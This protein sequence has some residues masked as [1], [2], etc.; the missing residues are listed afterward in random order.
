[1][2]YTA[3][4]IQIALSTNGFPVAV[5]GVMGP[6]TEGAISSFKA[7][8]GLRRRPLI[9]PLTAALLFGDREPQAITGDPLFPPWVNELGRHMHWHEITNNTELPSAAVHRLRNPGSSPARVPGADHRRQYRN[10][11]Q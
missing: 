6:E 4:Q 9:G 11:R 3:R 1:M 5:D 2:P 7:S 10:Q 8:H